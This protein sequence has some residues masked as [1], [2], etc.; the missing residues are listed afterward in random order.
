MVEI[1]TSYAHAT[2]AVRP[3]RATG[4]CIGAGSWA[5]E[6][7]RRGDRAQ[8]APAPLE[9]RADNAH[10]ARD[11]EHAARGRARM[12]KPALEPD[13]EDLIHESFVMPVCTSPEDMRA[14]IVPD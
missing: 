13:R 7:A 12:K 3:A 9:L 2:I 1:S 14:R 4:R 6:T 10:R 8:Q 11:L 5:T